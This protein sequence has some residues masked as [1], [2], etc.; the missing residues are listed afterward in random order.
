[1]QTPQNWEATI[2]EFV[3]LQSIVQHFQ[4][5]LNDTEL[6]LNPEEADELI[7]KG[8]PGRRLSCLALVHVAVPEVGLTVQVRLPLTTACFLLTAYQHVMF[9]GQD[10]HLW[11]VC[12]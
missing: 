4:C 8:P 5:W 7:Q 1:M 12:R 6:Q 9:S 10:S 3:V 11:S 2:E